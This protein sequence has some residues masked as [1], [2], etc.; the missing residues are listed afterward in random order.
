MLLL[1]LI[2]CAV[3]MRDWRPGAPGSCSRRA[4]CC[5]RSADLLDGSIEGTYVR[6]TF[7]DI[8]YAL[9]LV[10]VASSSRQPA[11]RATSVTKVGWVTLLMP[12]I[13]GTASLALAVWD[14]FARLETLA[15]LLSGVTLGLVLVRLALTFTAYTR[16]LASS[17]DEA[18]S[19]PLTGLGNRRALTQDLERLL[20]PGAP[21]S[22]IILFDLNGFKGYNDTYGHPAGD[23]LLQR[24]AGNLVAAQHGGRVYRMGGDE[25]CVLA[26]LGSRE[27]GDVAALAARA[28]AERGALY[29]ITS[30]V[31][32]GRAAGRDDEPVRGD[33]ARG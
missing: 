30:G 6:G 28:L 1:G 26:P 14:H 29:E 12:S 5:G 23:A 11:L 25:F 20:R 8:T 10:L 18:I 2:V 33:A 15:L 24:L 9:A 7:V 21:R 4:S 27:A 3:A 22:T 19:D 13:F 32:R 16:A 31:R 17:R